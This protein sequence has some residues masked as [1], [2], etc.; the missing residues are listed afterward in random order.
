MQSPHRSRR[1]PVRV[2]S[3][4]GLATRMAT[5]APGA[6]KTSLARPSRVVGSGGTSRGGR[7]VHFAADPAVGRCATTGHINDT[8]HHRC[9]RSEEH[10]SE[11]QSL[12]RISSAVFCLKNKT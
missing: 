4:T 10:T 8:E 7:L 2:L 11:L 3:G 5:P 9:G 1:Q 12:M 6:H